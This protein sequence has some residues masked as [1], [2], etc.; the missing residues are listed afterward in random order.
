MIH[1]QITILG[2]GESGIGAAQLAYKKGC[3]VF[4][5]DINNITNKNK[6]L[7]KSLNIC[8]EEKKHSENFIL[9]SNL[10]IKSPGISNTTSIIKKV[11]S[12]GIP[13][14]SEMEFAFNHI[15]NGKIIAI[16]GTNGKTTTSLLIYHLLKKAGYSV[17]LGGNIGKSMASLVADN[18]YDYYVVEVSSFQ[19]DDIDKFKP[20]IAIIL[21]IT[22]DHLDRYNHNFNQY[23][24]SKFNLIKNITQK[25]TF[26]YCADSK[27]IVDQL[28]KTHIKAKCLNVS[29]KVDTS[30]AYIANGKMFF[31]IQK[32][33]ESIDISHFSLEGKHNMINIMIS[34]ICARQLGVSLHNIIN[35]LISFKNRAHRM[36]RVT[37]INKVTFINDSKATNVDAV[38]Y[39]M[40]SISKKIIWIAGGIDKGNDYTPLMPSV[41]EKVIGLICLGKDNTQLKYH[42]NNQIKNIYETTDINK[43]VEKSYEW[44]AAVDSVVLL[45]PAC[46]SFDL[47]SSY[48]ERGEVFKKAI[49]NFKK[50]RNIL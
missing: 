25:D 17:A 3:K 23:V 48:Q 43:A 50:N 5:S 33:Q 44:G 40:E 42:F 31:T 8:F 46:A 24:S 30:D 49:L 1:D 28:R 12:K 41:D 18:S 27:A 36:E 45:S 37:T 16:T 9:S 22:P 2:T 11:K 38:Y 29:T 20:N 35:G 32:Q 6:M 34:V 19:L 26:I 14:I 10:I 39:A 15:K 13:L 21:N 7:L 4:V 47:F